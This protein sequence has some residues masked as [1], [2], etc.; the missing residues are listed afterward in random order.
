MPVPHAA[1]LRHVGVPSRTGVPLV[2]ATGVRVMVTL[3]GCGLLAAGVLPAQS[4]DVRL[5]DSARVRVAP[6]AK[7]AVPVVVDLAARGPLTVASLQG[8]IRWGSGR[9]TLDSIRAGSGWTVTTNAD[10]AG[11]VRLV[12]YSPSALPATGAVAV[13]HFTAAGTAGGTRVDLGVEAAGDEAGQ[14]IL[15]AVRPR[16]VAVCLAPPGQ[17]GDVNDDALVNVLD[18]QQIARHSVGLSVAVLAVLTDRGDVTADGAVNVMDAQQVAR[19]SVGLSAAARVATARYVPP[20]AAT[21]GVLGPDGVPASSVA[22]PFGGRAAL[23]AAVRGADGGELSGCAPEAWTSSNGAVARVTATGQV[24]GRGPGTASITVTSG[25]ASATVTVTVE[26]PP[27]TVALQRTLLTA[28]GGHSCLLRPDT[29]IVDC[30]GHDNVG[31]MG[32][33][34]PGGMQPLAAKIASAQPFVSVAAGA[35]HSCALTAAGEAFCWGAGTETTV[36][37]KVG[38]TVRF[39]ALAAGGGGNSAAFS[40]GQGYTCGLTEDGLAHCWGGN[41]L[42][43]LGTGDQ[44]SSATPRPVAQGVLRFAQIAAGN[45]HSCAITSTY[46]IHCWGGDNAAAIGMTG[47]PALGLGP[48]IGLPDGAGRPVQVIAGGGGGMGAAFSCALTELGRV[49][50]WGSDT[51]SLTGGDGPTP[52]RVAEAVTFSSLTARGVFACGL[53]AA[54]KAY[55]WGGTPSGQSAVPVPVGDQFTFTALAAG[56][57]PVLGAHVCGRQANGLVRCWGENTGGQVGDGNTAGPR[58]LPTLVVGSGED[59]RGANLAGRSFRYGNLTGA[60][61]AGA[62]LRR[63]ELVGAVLASVNLAN[64]R[65]DSANVGIA[66]FTG[67]SLAGVTWTEASFNSETKWP[68]G[69]NPEGLGMWGPGLDYAG[70]NLQGRGFRYQDFARATFTGTDFRR[71]ELVGTVFVDANLTNAQLDSSRLS[72]ADLSR[73]VV[74]GATWVGATFNS[75]TKWPAGFIPSGKGMLGPGLNYTGQNFSRRSLRYIDFKGATFTGADLSLTDLVGTVF[76]DATM[77]NARL[78]SASLSYADF[79]GASLNGVSWTGA[80]FN[81]QTKWPSGFTPAGKGMFGP[82]LDYSGRNLAGRSFRWQDFTDATFSSADLRRGDLTGA[83]FVNATLTNARLD[84]ANVSSADFTGAT[85]TGATWVGTRY[86]AQTKWPTGFDPS[87][88]G[89]ILEGG[90][91]EAPDHVPAELRPVASATRVVPHGV[92]EQPGNTTGT[93]RSRQAGL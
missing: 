67:A 12:T 87:A 27:V 14:S 2:A 48:A 75:Q 4:I 23:G 29:G 21:V 51:Y 7:V 58:A 24:E 61:F 73:A 59:Q 60:H 38:G 63:S 32:D 41:A 42:G 80:S 91:S 5:G 62:D 52:R 13:A 65:L 88:A 81:T 54:G 31:Q 19:H 18:A 37:V 86:N 28:G 44:T 50:C 40:Y 46:A 16:G 85:I 55:C 89:A 53:N 90:G 56:G 69:F 43:Q 3:L 71:A 15:S 83:M 17:W 77:T 70:R 36:P 74:S 47:D 79:T 66:D 92:M 68:A 84:S 8:R 11:M 22:V 82:G 25:T 33:S 35:A 1:L 20:P 10:S 78:D 30:W 45:T 9:L 34:V 57:H 72:E 49:Y 6:G 26:A 93:H 64:V 76:V 39:R